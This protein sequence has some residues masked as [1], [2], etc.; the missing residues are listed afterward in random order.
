MEKEVE[1]RERSPDDVYTILIDPSK[2][3]EDFEWKVS[4]PLESGVDRAVDWYGTHGI[5][6]TFTHLKAGEEKK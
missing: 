3:V 1:V 2:T 4:T 5:T 6:Q